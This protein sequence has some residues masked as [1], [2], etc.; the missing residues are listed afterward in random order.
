MIS[1]VYN[2]YRFWLAI[3]FEPDFMTNTLTYEIGPRTIGT[4]D[5]NEYAEISRWMEKYGE[6]KL[7]EL[8]KSHRD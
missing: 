2:L 3:D 5:D 7:A 1:P 6:V 8:D 4:M